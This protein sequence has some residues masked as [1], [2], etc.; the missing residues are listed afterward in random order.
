MKLGYGGGA[1]RDALAAQVE[2]RLH[3]HV[4]LERVVRRGLRARRRLA[5]AQRV[6]QRADHVQRLFGGALVAHADYEL[7]RRFCARERCC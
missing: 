5:L 6:R 3:E 1:V 2:Q 4:D 7:V